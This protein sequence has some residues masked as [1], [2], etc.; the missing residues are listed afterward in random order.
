MSICAHCGREM[1]N[2]ADLWGTDE[3]G[4]YVQALCHPDDGPSCYTRVTVDRE[5]VGVRRPDAE[6]VIQYRRYPEDDWYVLP[7]PNK[8]WG[9]TLAYYR[10]MPNL[11]WEHKRLA[12]RFLSPFQV[13]EVLPDPESVPT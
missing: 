5:P 8:T 13:I 11:G 7:L 2:P 9:P 3:F 10:T 1:A 12:M 4:D 6:V